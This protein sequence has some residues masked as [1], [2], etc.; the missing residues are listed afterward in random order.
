QPQSQ[1]VTVGADVTF[2]VGAEGTAPLN[3][4]W[5]LEGSPLTG[6]TNA[7]LLLSNVQLNQAGNYSVVV[8]NSVNSISSS[9]A[10]LT[11]VSASCAPLASGAVGWWRLD[12]NANGALPGNNGVLVG[13]PVFTNGLVGQ[14]LYLN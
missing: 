14:A 2:S 11:V 1:T 6:E 12:G 7:S 5:R 9:N 3:Y 8:G 4:Q 13:G 10:H